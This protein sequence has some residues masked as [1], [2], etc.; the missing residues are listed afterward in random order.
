LP[1]GDV[2]RNLVV[3]PTAPGDEPT[4]LV[5]K[6]DVNDAL[7]PFLSTGAAYKPGDFRGD[8]AGGRPQDCRAG[9]C[10]INGFTCVTNADCPPM[11]PNA[12]GDPIGWD[13]KVNALDV[14]YSCAQAQGNWGNLNDAVFI[15]LSCDMNGDCA[16]D[17]N[18]LRELV[19][20]ILE[21]ELGDANLDGVV[22]AADAAIVNNSLA[23]P[24]AHPCWTDG[25]FDFDGDVDSDDSICAGG[26]FG[27]VLTAGGGSSSPPDG[28]VDVD[29][30]LCA[31]DAFVGIDVVCVGKTDL[32]P[33]DC[34]CVVDAD[35]SVQSCGPTCVFGVCSC[36]SAVGPSAECDAHTGGVN[37]PCVND[38]CRLI[39]VDDLLAELDAF[40]GIYACSCP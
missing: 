38:R 15:D 14:Q 4:F 6:R 3:P 13:A 31:L 37:V 9:R 34:P 1:A 33:C 24:P 26:I 36:E 28:V 18:D 2:R 39:D 25:D 5:P 23:N 40:A 8:V 11:N 10:S 30:L 29:D 16:V 35:C 22:D 19:L 20:T 12:G 32:V 21:A 27:D 7:M 17:A